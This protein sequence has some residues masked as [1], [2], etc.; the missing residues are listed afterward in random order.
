MKNRSRSK[1][2][3]TSKRDKRGT[4]KR[5][6]LNKSKGS[7]KTDSRNQEKIANRTTLEEPV[8]NGVGEP[9]KPSSSLNNTL[10]SSK[11]GSLKPPESLNPVNNFNVG[12]MIKRGAR[13]SRRSNRVSVIADSDIASVI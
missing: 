5:D 1:M 13:L 2:R 8:V 7:F 9:K 11:S 4:G 10:L 12:S 3:K 6:K